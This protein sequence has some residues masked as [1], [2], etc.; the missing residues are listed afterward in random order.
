[1]LE[2]LLLPDRTGLSLVSL[3]LVHFALG[4]LKVKK[5]SWCGHQGD[6]G[7]RVYVVP[8]AFGPIQSHAVRYSID[9]D[10]YKSKFLENWTLMGTIRKP[11]IAAVNGYAV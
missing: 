5:Q 11:I 4:E 3:S 9:S 10:V 1:M 2:L 8:H 7:K 6:E